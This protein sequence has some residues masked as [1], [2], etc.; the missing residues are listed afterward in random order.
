MRAPTVAWDQQ[1]HSAHLS[2]WP[3]HSSEGAEVGGKKAWRAGAGRGTY[4]RA[5]RR[6]SRAG[7]GPVRPGPGVSVRYS[8]G[9]APIGWGTG[10]MSG[11]WGEW[12]PRV[13]RRE[14]DTE[15]RTGYPLFRPL[16]FQ[17]SK[18]IPCG[19]TPVLVCRI[20]V[21]AWQ[22]VLVSCPVL[23]PPGTQAWMHACLARFQFP[24]AGARDGAALW[25]IAAGLVLLVGLA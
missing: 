12:H 10:G 5:R 22:A 21:R 20:L 23:P 13:G 11:L 18:A 2:A 6:S 24:L 15:I 16:P 1:S 14:G 3:R 8:A 9:Q 7:R 19:C 17:P 25:M 4:A